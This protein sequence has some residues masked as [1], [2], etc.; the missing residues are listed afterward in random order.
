M[1]EKERQKIEAGG[2]IKPGESWAALKKAG[3]ELKKRGANI[4]ANR[5]KACRHR[6]GDRHE[7]QRQILQTE[8]RQDKIKQKM[9]T[10]KS[11]NTGSKPPRP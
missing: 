7:A 8:P 11:T 5:N 9:R 4:L 1:E 6:G 2:K 10:A 3:W